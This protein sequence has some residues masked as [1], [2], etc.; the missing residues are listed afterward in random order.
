MSIHFTLDV[1]PPSGHKC[2]MVT[3]DQPLASP[4]APP[5]LP[6]K[7]R[8]HITIADVEAIASL[9]I[10]RRMTETEACALL[11]IKSP[12]WYQW[13]AR[14]GN[15]RRNEDILARTRAARIHS[16]IANIEDGAVGVG[17]HKRADWRAADRLLGI[18]DP[19]RFGQ[20]QA[21]VVQQPRSEAATVNVWCQIVRGLV[22]PPAAH[23]IDVQ[24]VKSIADKPSLQDAIDADLLASM[25]KPAR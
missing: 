10:T 22:D 2:L 14:N 1:N 5:S 25:G 8:H 11:G 4:V 23:A 15:D 13:K 19:S 16:Q 6:K 9:V 3:A 7:P 21:Q 24:E 12:A 20:Q 18:M 17:N